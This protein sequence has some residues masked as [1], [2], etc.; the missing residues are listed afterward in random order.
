[1]ALDRFRLNCLS[2]QSQ[3]RNQDPHLMP[4]QLQQCRETYES[5]KALLQPSCQNRLF[6]FSSKI[7][8]G[9][10]ALQAE[11][12]ESIPKG[13]CWKWPR[14][15]LATCTSSHRLLIWLQAGQL[16]RWHL[17]AEVHEQ[18]F[19]AKSRVSLSGTGRGKRLLAKILLP[20]EEATPII[21]S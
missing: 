14:G 9:A 21:E 4:A 12:P 11:I 5:T 19:K 8:E 20:G 7:S 18:F 10:P 3:E 15:C 2:R 16:H 17:Y 1:M 13:Q 6:F